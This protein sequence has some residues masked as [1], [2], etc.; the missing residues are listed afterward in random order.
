VVRHTSFTRLF[1]PPNRILFG[2]CDNVF[3]KDSEVKRCTNIGLIKKILKLL[4]LLLI[5]AVVIK[6][7]IFGYVYYQEKQ[8]EAAELAFGGEAGWGW[9]NDEM[10]IQKKTGHMIDGS[11]KTSLRRVYIK[12]NY[13]VV[14][15]IMRD[16]SL[17]AEAIYL[18]NCP[19]DSKIETST[20][21]SSGS[22]YTLRCNEEGTAL[23]TSAVF[24]TY[25]NASWEE[26]FGGFK[27]DEYLSWW[28]FT[29]LQKEQT[30]RRAKVPDS[31]E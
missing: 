30:L 5:A 13:Q 1:S 29:E 9:H 19:P 25:E 2:A 28:T 18:T 24:S 8:E 10:R 3:E 7:G 26:D 11:Q 16:G 27:V 23:W 14:A 4:G 12:E 21:Y 17:R 20:E 15:D 31:A 22:K 6:L